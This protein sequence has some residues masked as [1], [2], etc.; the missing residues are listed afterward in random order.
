[1]AVLLGKASEARFWR[2]LEFHCQMTGIIIH[3]EMPAQTLVVPMFGGQTVEE[4]NHFRPLVF[5]IRH[6]GL[7]APIPRM[8]AAASLSAEGARM[9]S[10][11]LPQVCRE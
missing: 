4:M 11:Q 2:L 3:P 1:M 6:S 10:T 7:P 5:Q 8:Q 9:C